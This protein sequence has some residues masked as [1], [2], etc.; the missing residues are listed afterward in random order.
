MSK[1]L[2]YLTKEY[3]GE[4]IG[5]RLKN[6]LNWK[7]YFPGMK[8]ELKHYFVSLDKINK[9]IIGNDPQGLTF[10]AYF[11]EEMFF[12][13]GIRN[14]LEIVKIPLLN[15]PKI[16]DI[17]EITALLETNKNLEDEKFF[18]FYLTHPFFEMEDFIEPRQ[19]VKER[20]KM[21]LEDL[22]KIV[23]KDKKT[24]IVISDPLIAILLLLFKVLPLSSFKQSVFSIMVYNHSE[25]GYLYDLMIYG[26]LRKF[27]SSRT[28]FLG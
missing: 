8:E 15:P 26:C 19:E 25:V 17:E 24:F 6:S 22:G 1:A 2:N 10:L 20:L 18:E 28:M 27:L 9:I 16:Y 14:N 5:I 4:A 12:K 13:N 7:T 21:F 11:L 3:L 23:E